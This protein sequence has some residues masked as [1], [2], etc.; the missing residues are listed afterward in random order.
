MVGYKVGFWL[1]FLMVGFWLVFGW[2][3]GWFFKACFKYFPE[4]KVQFFKAQNDERNELYNIRGKKG[5]KTYRKK[6][7][8]F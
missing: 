2:F 5:S 1:V 8:I 6:K 3:F 7:K 4:V